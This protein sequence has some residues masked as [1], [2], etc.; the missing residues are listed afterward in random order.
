[1]QTQ[2]GKPGFID[3]LML[4][5]LSS[6]W[7]FSFYFI[8]KGLEA[9]SWSEVA[10]FRI[11]IAFCTLSP[12]LLFY[13]AKVPFRML[14]YILL[15]GLLG[16]GLPPFLFSLAETNISS[17]LAGILNATT[18]LFALVFGALFFG[19]RT[20]RFQLMGVIIGF[21]GA[22]TI[23]LSRMED[24]IVFH[25]GYAL[26][27]VAATAC[28]GLSAN[29]L[30]SKIMKEDIHPIQISVYGFSFLGPFAGIYLWKTAALSRSVHDPIAQESIIYLL[31]LGIFGT[32][33][34]VLFFN[35]LTKRTSALFASFTTYLIPIV[36]IIIGLI[37]KEKLHWMQLAGFLIIMSGVLL[38]NRKPSGG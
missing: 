8:K 17:S 11:F 18:P 28:Y 24:A 19:L 30:K 5:G 22:V 13:R 25:P 20:N 35:T 31:I 32:G 4:I 21:A 10:A 34:A 29:I 38:A 1:M 2:Q 7:G 14:G 27:V 33:I 23:V 37:V 15:A 36:A 12:L 9:F 16:S 26:L 3:W 6:M